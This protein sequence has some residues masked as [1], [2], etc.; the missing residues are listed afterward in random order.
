MILSRKKNQATSAQGEDEQPKKRYTGFQKLCFVYLFAVF[1]LPQYFGIPLPGF[2]L[3]AQRIMLIC[4]FAA[5]FTNQKR[6]DTFFISNTGPMGGHIL[7][8]L[9]FVFV[10]LATAILRSSPKSFL[11]FFADAVLPMLLMVYLASHIFTLEELLKFFKVVLII[12]C[13]SCYLDALILHKNP[14][15]FIHTIK[16]VEGG[17]TWRASSYR[18]AAMASHPIGLGMYLIMMTP[19]MCIDVEGR[20][21]NVAKNWGVVLLVGGA[22]LLTGS[23]MPQATFALELVIL[24]VLTEKS[25]RRALI[26][27]VL[28]VGVLAVLLVVLLRNESHVRRYVILN[29]YQIIDSVFGTKLTLDEFGYWQW[30]LNSSSTDYR[31]LLP[32]LFFS[33][34]FDPLLGTGVS[35]DRIN[36]ITIVIEGRTIVSIDN[37]YVLQY[38]QF[39]WPGL[40]TIL[41][42]FAYMLLQ[43]IAGTIKKRGAVCK[44]LLVSFVLYF[45]NLWFVADLGTFKYAFSLFGLAFAYSKGRGLSQRRPMAE[46]STTRATMH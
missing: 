29:L 6:A 42:V 3:T 12:V 13:V 26:P 37:Y 18:V 41:L 27:Y 14:Y 28:V 39:A 8:V 40:I 34:D 2:A 9:P 33:D 35:N 43:C 11:N 17:S 23:R 5:I 30:A 24:F 44:A 7:V 10:S 32:R 45:I 22:V 19:L 1:A 20:V 36:S 16:S 4:L 31:S 15:D 25:A 21:V 46:G 38:L